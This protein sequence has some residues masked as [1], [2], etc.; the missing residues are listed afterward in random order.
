MIEIP[1]LVEEVARRL[2]ADGYTYAE[3]YP[4]HRWRNNDW[5]EDPAFFKLVD[6]CLKILR[7]FEEK[8][9]HSPHSK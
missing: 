4:I 2:H 6:A 7:I 3:G 8:K 9:N 1:K 5:P